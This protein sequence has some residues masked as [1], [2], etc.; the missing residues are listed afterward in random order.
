MQ[1]YKK[2]IEPLRHPP[3]D[4]QQWLQRWIMAIA[5]LSSKN[6]PPS[7]MPNIWLSD[8]LSAIQPVKEAWVVCREPVYEPQVLNKT[9][10]YHMVAND[11]RYE[12]ARDKEAFTSQKRKRKGTKGSQGDQK[13]PDNARQDSL[14][15]KRKGSECPSPKPRC[16]ICERAKCKSWNCFYRYPE[17]AYKGWIPIPEVLERAQRNLAQ[18]KGKVRSSE[19]PSKRLRSS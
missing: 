12:L 9:L 16:E 6:I 19:P 3:R 14:S 5:E 7:T 1:K 4:F 10:T 15:R 11:F 8:F 13:D 18:E 17:K 2:A